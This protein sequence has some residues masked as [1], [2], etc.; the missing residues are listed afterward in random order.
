MTMPVKI[1]SHKIGSNEYMMHAAKMFL[2][3]YW[4]LILLPVFVCIALATV[5][6][7]FL[8]VAAMV[9]F[10]ILPMMQTLIYY[11]YTLYKEVAYSIL[12]KSVEISDDGIKIIF[13]SES[14]DIEPRQPQILSWDRFSVISP[15]KDHLLLVFN[16]P[17]FCF[18]AIP[19]NAF[20]GT[21]HLKITMSELNQHIKFEKN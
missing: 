20:D 6:K 3:K 11:R 21:E 10:L 16:K 2:S 17:K 5:N 1:A 15:R 7:N 19:Y 12:K 13:E 9:A 18:L 14:D 8:F 4:A